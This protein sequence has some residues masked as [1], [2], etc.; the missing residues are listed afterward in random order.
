MQS[1][2][3]GNVTCRRQHAQPSPQRRAAGHDSVGHGYEWLELL[4]SSF[5]NRLPQPPPV[6][7][8]LSPKV[9]GPWKGPAAP[10]NAAPLTAIGP[11]HG[12]MVIAAPS[13]SKHWGL[14]SSLVSRLIEKPRL[15]F[16]EHR[17]TEAGG[18][19]AF[20]DSALLGI[21]MVNAVRLAPS[22]AF[23]LASCRSWC[24]PNSP[25]AIPVAM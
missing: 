1:A 19:H 11:V 18:R 25:V 20:Q 22:S 23:Q 16:D 10:I 5:L 3:A 24:N 8:Q 21:A 13:R 2:V 9:G 4:C 17:V 15:R 14:R 12:E 6:Q 7:S